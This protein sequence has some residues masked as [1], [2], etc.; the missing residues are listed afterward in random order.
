MFAFVLFVLACYGITQILVYGKI[1]EGLRTSVPKKLSFG[2]YRE[3]IHKV[4]KYYVHCTMCIGFLVGIF[5]FCSMQ[6][7]KLFTVELSLAN[8]FMFAAISS[9]TSYFLCQLVDDKG[10]RFSCS[11]ERKTS[12]VRNEED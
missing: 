2:R 6:G 7:T 1:F 4:L 3:K 11:S 8:V 5:V 9:G 10:I 12:E